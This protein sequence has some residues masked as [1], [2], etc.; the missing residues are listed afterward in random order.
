M[1]PEHWLLDEQ[2]ETREALEQKLLRELTM[3]RPPKVESPPGLRT[4][5]VSHQGL[6][7]QDLVQSNS[8]LQIRDDDPFMGLWNDPHSRHPLAPIAPA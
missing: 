8:N 2:R 7:H 3:S 6:N 4:G 5:Q 1:P